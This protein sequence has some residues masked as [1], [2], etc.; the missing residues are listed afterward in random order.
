VKTTPT[1]PRTIAAGRSLSLSVLT[2]RAAGLGAATATRP[3]F[4]IEMSCG[5]LT[6]AAEPRLLR[7]LQIGESV[8]QI[9]QTARELRLEALGGDVQALRV[10]IY[11]LSGRVL[12]DRASQAAH[13]EIPL[14]QRSGRPLAQGVYLYVLT[15]EGSFG[16]RTMLQK[17]IVSTQLP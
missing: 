6:S 13:L 4:T 10:Q 17:L 11:D 14:M 1:L 15:L 3:Y 5:V 9:E 12:I 16:S 7:P 8:L 2:E